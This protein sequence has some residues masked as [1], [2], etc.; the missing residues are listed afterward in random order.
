MRWGAQPPL[1]RSWEQY[2]SREGM[3]VVEV[4]LLKKTFTVGLLSEVLCTSFY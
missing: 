3:R 4:S 2:V 1:A